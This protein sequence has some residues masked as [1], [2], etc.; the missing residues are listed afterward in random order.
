M[1]K[2]NYCNNKFEW[3][4]DDIRLE[5]IILAPILYFYLFIYLFIYL[6]MY[7]FIYLFIYLYIYLLIYLF[8]YVFEVSALLDVRHCPKLQ[9][10]AISRKTNNPILRKFQSITLCNLKDNYWTKLEKMAKK[11]IL[12]PILACFTPNLGPQFL[13]Q[14]L[15][16]PV[17]RHYFKLSFYV[18]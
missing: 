12:D 8:I 14:F 9:F 17:A 3:T 13:L 10:C 15:S 4:L 16:L 18:I 5:K 7:L 11:L 1:Y 2:A 6:F